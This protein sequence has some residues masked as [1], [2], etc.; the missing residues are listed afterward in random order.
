MPGNEQSEAIRVVVVDPLRVVRRGI[1]LLVDA[2]PGMEAHGEAADAD[3]CMGILR[4]SG[5]LRSTVT[6]V[7]LGLPGD[8]DSFWLIRSLRESFPAVAVLACGSNGEA[9]DASQALFVGADGYLDKDMPP[10]RF[11]EAIRRVRRGER[12][13]EGVSL[14]TLGSMVEAIRQQKE[15]EEILSDREREVLVL[16]ARGLTSRQVATRLGL[17]E[18][19]VTTH[20]DHIYRKLGV[21]GRVAAVQAAVSTGLVPL[22]SVSS[23]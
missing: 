16:V 8:R 13:L 10:E 18:R 3:E 12:V 23:A 21:S 22:G 14:S 17:S 5:H 2:E 6:L 15:P 7:C 9:A 4:G 20:L 19:T 11:L 1:G